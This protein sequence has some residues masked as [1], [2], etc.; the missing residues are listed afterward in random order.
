VDLNL[1][2]DGSLYTLE[3]YLSDT[4]VNIA[5]RKSV[6]PE[7]DTILTG[8]FEMIGPNNLLY[9]L[10]PNT[11]GNFYTATNDFTETGEYQLVFQWRGA[12]YI[13]RDRKSLLPDDVSI[14]LS[15][16][17]G[18]IRQR[19]VSLIFVD[20]SEQDNFYRFKYF[21]NGSEVNS[22]SI[23]LIRDNAFRGGLGIYNFPERASLEDTIIVELQ[24]IS[25]SYFL[26]LSTLRQLQES[27]NLSGAVSGNPD[28]NLPPE[29]SGYFAALSTV[30]DTVFLFE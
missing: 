7:A 22:R 19:S 9:R 17:S 28:S 21:L 4:T 24:S 18:N 8:P 27:G 20:P 10:E 1:G 25:R 6:P 13:A 14:S 2:T 30:R 29:M 16:V 5:L 12:S 23:R 3:G 11:T 26:Y 15:V